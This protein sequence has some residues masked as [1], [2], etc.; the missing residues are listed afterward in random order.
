MSDPPAP[1]KLMTISV[2]AEIHRRLRAIYVETGETMTSVVN[3]AIRA[4]LDEHEDK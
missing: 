2:P 4:W 1:N 3:K